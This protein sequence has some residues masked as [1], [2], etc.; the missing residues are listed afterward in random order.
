ME[1]NYYSKYLKYKNKYLE[2]KAQL[3]GDPYKCDTKKT[4][5]ACNKID[6]CKWNTET[7]TCN[8]RYCKEFE[9]ITK[10]NTDICNT[11]K[12]KTICD[13]KSCIDIKKKEP[14]YI[15]SNCTGNYTGTK[16]TSCRN[17]VCNDYNKKTCPKECFNLND[18]GFDRCLNRKEL[19]EI[20][21]SHTIKFY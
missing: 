18:S 15:Y 2:L 9:N 11:N 6:K 13:P 17:K 7:G 3:G 21:D 10:C 20:P 4:D 19:R 14:C 16:F 5:T 1:V 12:E 8:I